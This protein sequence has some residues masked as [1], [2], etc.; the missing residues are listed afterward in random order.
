MSQ[1][2]GNINT[3]I[4]KGGPGEYRSGF[5]Q[6]KHTLWRLGWINKGGSRTKPFRELYIYNPSSGMGTYLAWLNP[7]LEEQCQTIQRK[8][9]MQAIRRACMTLLMKLAELISYWPIR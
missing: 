3:V 9:I 4:I 8:G 1:N 7:T 2:K 5:N 6:Y